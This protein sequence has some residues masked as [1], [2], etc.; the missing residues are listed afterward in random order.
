M[1]S[2]LLVQFGED[3][4]ATLDRLS[5]RTGASKAAILRYGLSLL[6]VAIRESRRGNAIGVVNGDRVVNRLVGIWDDVPSEQCE[7]S[8]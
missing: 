7:V 6:T 3:Q 2:K 8:I 1:S 4:A 5:E